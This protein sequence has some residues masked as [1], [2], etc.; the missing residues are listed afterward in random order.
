M[1]GIDFIHRMASEYVF[2]KS[3]IWESFKK[4]LLMVLILKCYSFLITSL[5]NENNRFN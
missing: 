1:S 3:L 4:F 5:K 2:N